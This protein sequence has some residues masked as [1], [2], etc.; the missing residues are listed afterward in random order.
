MR[1]RLRSRAQIS[2]SR[3]VKMKNVSQTP[4]SPACLKV[5]DVPSLMLVGSDHWI[6]ANVVLTDWRAGL[7]WSEACSLPQYAHTVGILGTR[8]VLCGCL[9]NICGNR[10]VNDVAGDQEKGLSV[11]FETKHHQLFPDPY[12]PGPVPELDQMSSTFPSTL[13]VWFLYP[14]V[15]AVFVACGTR[16]SVR[17]QERL[18]RGAEGCL[19]CRDETGKGKTQEKSGRCQE[20]AVR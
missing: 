3:S 2:L 7:A 6:D 18:R 19:G 20:D 1:P 13:P 15:T 9:M 8:W 12:R 4:P 11:R 5:S 17:R 10:L 16:A 14:I